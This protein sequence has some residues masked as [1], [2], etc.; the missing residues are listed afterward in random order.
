[1]LHESS[2]TEPTDCRITAGLREGKILYYE[3]H[4]TH[5]FGGVKNYWLLVKKKKAQI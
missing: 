3:S 2:W 5:D 4:V 1:M